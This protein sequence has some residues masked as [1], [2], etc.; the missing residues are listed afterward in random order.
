MTLNKD[1]REKSKRVTVLQANRDEIVETEDTSCPTD[2]TLE[3]AEKDKMQETK[4]L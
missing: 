1:Q 3:D 4:K 2:M